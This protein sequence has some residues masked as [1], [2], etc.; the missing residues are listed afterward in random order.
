M[1]ARGSQEEGLVSTISYE[2]GI[3]HNLMQ[4]EFIRRAS[5][6]YNEKRNLTDFY[7]DIFICSVRLNLNINVSYLGDFA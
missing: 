7:Q 6:W 1:A 5:D 4:I 3:P 2:K